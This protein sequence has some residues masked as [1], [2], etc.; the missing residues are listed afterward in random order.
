VQ[1]TPLFFCL[2]KENVTQCATSRNEV[3]S[4]ERSMTKARTAE[5]NRNMGV[6]LTPDDR[7]K[8]KA[9][10]RDAHTSEGGVLRDLLRA[11]KVVSA[12]R[13]Q[14]YGDP[15]TNDDDAV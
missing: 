6:R 10:A 3:F 1:G 14:L 4:K 11:A 15:S 12:P 13:Y 2:T 8:L 9:L 7:K 5:T